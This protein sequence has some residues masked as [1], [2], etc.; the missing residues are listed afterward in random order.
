M[1]MSGA[2]VITRKGARF[3]AGWIGV[4]NLVGLVAH[5]PRIRTGATSVPPRRPLETR[6]A[7]A[8]MRS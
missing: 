5:S 3:D 1:E 2:F 6:D 7:R 8:P 4:P